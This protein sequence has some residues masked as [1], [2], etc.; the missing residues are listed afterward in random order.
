MFFKTGHILNTFHRLG[1]DFS[2]KLRSN[3]FAKIT[4]NSGSIFLRK[5]TG[6]LS[7]S[8]AFLGLRFLTSLETSRT[9]IKLLLRLCLVRLG[10]LG[11]GW[12]MSSNV[13]L[14]ATVLQ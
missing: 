9:V 12:P 7:V 8:V 3:N 1:K 11:R 4:D 10:K 13:E 6:I 14:K 2:F 5:T